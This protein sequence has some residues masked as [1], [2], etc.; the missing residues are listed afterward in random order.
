MLQQHKQQLHCTTLHCIDGHQYQQHHRQLQHH[1]RQLQHHHLRRAA[2]HHRAFKCCSNTSSNCTA[3]HCTALMGTRQSFKLFDLN[4]IEQPFAFYK[5]LIC[6][7]AECHALNSLCAH[8][9]TQC[10]AHTHMTHAC[11]SWSNCTALACFTILGKSSIPFFCSC[12]R[13]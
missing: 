3:L 13:S 5:I 6:P 8:V 11:T 9:P 10:H 2:S 12:T 1:L 4:M 7:K